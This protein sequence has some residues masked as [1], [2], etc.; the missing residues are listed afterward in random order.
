MIQ[1]NQGSAQTLFLVS[2]W[3]LCTRQL[4]IISSGKLY[5]LRADIFKIK[6][7]VVAIDSIFLG[8]IL[9]MVVVVVLQ[10]RW[11]TFEVRGGA[12]IRVHA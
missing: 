12:T 5:A 7:C 6:L 10:R 4:E 11:K 8:A 2:G 9:P 1:H 3:G